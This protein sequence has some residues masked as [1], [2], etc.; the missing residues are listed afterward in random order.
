MPALVVSC[1][2]AALPAAPRLPQSPAIL[3]A[4]TMLAD[5]VGVIYGTNAT[6]EHVHS[7]RISVCL[8]ANQADFNQARQLG[9]SPFWL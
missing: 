8:P 4:R 9:P 1:Q 6:A 5:H 3:H 2:W 7:L